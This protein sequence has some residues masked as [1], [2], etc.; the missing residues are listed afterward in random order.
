M[1]FKAFG[2]EKISLPPLPVACTGRGQR[3]M[4]TPSK[5]EF[6]SRW[7]FGQI[8]KTFLRKMRFYL[9]GSQ[10]QIMHTLPPSPVT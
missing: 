5:T 2:L 1:F 3:N 4:A 8:S 6:I 9:D 7:L 10:N